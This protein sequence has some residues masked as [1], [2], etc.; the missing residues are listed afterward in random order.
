MAGAAFTLVR[1]PVA[2]GMPLLRLAGRVTLEDGAAL[3]QQLQAALAG[4]ARLRLD[5]AE[6]VRLDGGAAALLQALVLQQAARG[7]LLE[8]SA[9]RGEPLRLLEL[10]ACRDAAACERLAPQK[11]G[12]L[13]DVGNFAVGA[14]AHTRAI[15][16]FAGDLVSGLL[17]AVRRPR[18][19]HLTE[20]GQLVERAGMDGVPI[21][22]LMHFLVG[23]VL[24]LQ[25]AMQLHRFGG[26][27]FLAN[28]VGLSVV[29]EFGPLLTAI[30][31]AGRSGAG[32]AA[33][34]GTM[35][36]N[37]EVDALRT[38]GQDPQG[39]LVFPRVLT[40]LLVVPVLTLL[41][42]FAGILGGLLVAIA[43]LQQPVTVYVQGLQQAVDLGDVGTGLLKSVAFA[44]AIG[45]IA[46]QRGLATRGGA[47]GVGNATTSAVV[48]SLFTLVVIDAVFTN[49][50]SLVGW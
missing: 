18:S 17:R 7:G 20:L 47:A 15:L 28:L 46:C 32:Y 42:N 5:L 34:L 16:S 24:G 39:F 43:Y 33:E 50:F 36:V 38:L 11:P 41:A 21:I 10:Y 23:A 48:T 30:L 26:D 6:V 44:G 14:A 8:L 35:T 29:R 4:D 31:V 9:A 37:E 3:W 13:E 27:A 40:L 1:D 19:V 45:L 25:G 49:V 12:L 22:G 2:D